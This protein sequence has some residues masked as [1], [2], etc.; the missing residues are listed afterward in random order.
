LSALPVRT[1]LILA[2]SERKS[3]T[4]LAWSSCS[5]T[6]FKRSKG[7]V[8]ISKCLSVG[9]VSRRKIWVIG[10]GDTEVVPDG[11]PSLSS[12]RE[13]GSS[14]GRSGE[15]GQG[16]LGR[17]FCTDVDL[18]TG[19]RSMPL[20]AVCRLLAALT[21]AALYWDVIGLKAYCLL[22]GRTIVRF[23]ERRRPAF[24]LV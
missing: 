21:R 24:G 15:T 4:L 18:G 2:C 10:R 7:S 3:G 14:A 13:P 16:G 11:N 17:G 22:S 23:D 12:K 19:E 6:R 8:S 20:N 1:D 5:G 9:C